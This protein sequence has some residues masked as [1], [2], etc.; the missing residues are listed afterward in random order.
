MV[1]PLPAG[2]VAVTQAS[3]CID[4]LSWTPKLGPIPLVYGSFRPKTGIGPKGEG[5]DP[6]CAKH[7]SGAHKRIFGYVFV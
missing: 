4:L 5:G 7:N 6:A 2:V 1:T 3:W